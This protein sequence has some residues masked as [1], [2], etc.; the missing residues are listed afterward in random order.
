[1]AMDVPVG[2]PLYHYACARAHWQA[3]RF[4]E[5]ADCARRAIERENLP[6]VAW[7]DLGLILQHGDDLDGSRACLERAVALGANPAAAHLVLGN[8]LK[9][10]GELERAV[11]EY[12]SAVACEP[13]FP[14]AHANA[15]IVLH[16][17]G[18]NLEALDHAV[19]AMELEPR[20]LEPRITRALV[21]GR[22]QGFDAA[23]PLIGEILQDAPDHPSALA[24][25]LIALVRLDRFEEGA[26]VARR[27]TE[28]HPSDAKLHEMLGLCLRMTG[29][30]ADAQRAIERAE[31]LSD[32]RG[33]VLVAKAELL[34]E[35]GRSAEAEALLHEALS[36]RDDLAAAWFG[37][38]GLRSF[39]R[40]DPL[41]AAMERALA[42]SPRLAAADDRIV[43]HFALGNAQLKAG[44]AEHAFE[45]LERGNRM[46]RAA[47]DYDVAADER[48]MESIAARFDSR[49]LERLSGSVDSDAAPIFIVGMPRSGTTLI[50]QIV[51]SHPGVHAAGEVTYLMEAVFGKAPP[52]YPDFAEELQPADLRA[53][54]SAYLARFEA[55]ASPGARIVD[56]LPANFLYAGLIRLLF[57]RARIVHSRRDALDTCFSC[58]TT[59]FTGRQDFAYDL[60]DIG[61]YYRAYERL[62]AH[63]RAV[64]TPEVLL[65]LRYEDVVGDLDGSVRRLLAFCGL[66]WDA[67]CL[68]F[69][70]TER[71]IRTASTSQ[72]R[73]PLYPTSVGR[74][75][76]YR[77]RLEPVLEALF[78]GGPR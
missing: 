30:Y 55:A 29:R 57:P 20:F 62:M 9:L 46:Q 72:V 41:I 64:L 40:G 51:A 63:W 56:K 47:L 37:L 31:G 69:H 71:P 43:M 68:R 28:L 34:T 52:A 25:L 14:E 17:L 11:L 22:L 76:P 78:S 10:L 61:R 7:Y 24:A 36:L 48:L 8:T 53:L 2:H 35:L 73:T 39:A 19:R 1:M 60:T 32:D 33:S 54:G 5:A 23:L 59:L 50:E 3:Q 74:A 70:E 44:N 15:A 38:V 4:R 58:Y 13:R 67:A 26:L 45:H 66:P 65:E 16:T 12:R 42:T 21:V 77:D 6:P 49:T 18:R 75:A 27:A